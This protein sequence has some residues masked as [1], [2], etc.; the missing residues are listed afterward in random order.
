MPRVPG[1]EVGEEHMQRPRGRNGRRFFAERCPL[2][3]EASRGP[4]P[5]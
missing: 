5:V 1:G 4:S 2:L 3:W